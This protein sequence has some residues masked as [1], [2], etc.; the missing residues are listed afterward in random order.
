[1]FAREEPLTHALAPHYAAL[2]AIRTR[3]QLERS[4][5][6]A[7]LKPELERVLAGVERGD[8]AAVIASETSHANAASTANAGGAATANGGRVRV[9]A[10]NIQRGRRFDALRGALANDPE[11]ASAD[12]LL[13]SEVD[14]GMGRSGN[15]NVARALADALG[16]SYAFGVS[17]LVLE[18]DF[19]ENP[20][21][22]PN[23]LALAG[24]AILSKLP[25]ARVAN[26]DLPELRDKFSSSEKRLGKKRALV[27]ELGG[28]EPLVVACGHLDSN[29]SPR[30][31]AQ[32]LG[33]LLAC[34]ESFGRAR[35]LV[36]GDFNTTTYDLSSPPA[37]AWN[38]LHKLWVNGFAGTIA[39]YLTPEK[40]YEK[41]V[42]EELSKHAFTVEGFN[43]RARGTLNY[44]LSDPFAIQKTR[45][46]VGGLLT[47][48]LQRLLRPWNGVVP[49]RLDWFA[50]RGILPHAPRVVDPRGPDGRPISD[51]A[52][53]LVD[54]ER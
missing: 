10:W 43:D 16:M 46:A 15:R 35:M 33:A 8:H 21:G 49:A 17:Y 30:Q 2:R 13:L 22:A 3:R 50:G 9:A 34:A 52:A 36:G 40:H 27:A 25:I 32:Q 5:L 6:Y 31:R 18:D 28:G 39:H 42:F 14:C 47:R 19:G 37:L 54:V 1:M 24:T 41:V 7:E 44:D 38:I 12:V 53:I 20:D 11:L 26:A 48:L 29:A 4:P 23:T 45:K 51:H